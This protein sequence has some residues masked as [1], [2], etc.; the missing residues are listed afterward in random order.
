MLDCLSF[1]LCAIT[2]EQLLKCPSSGTEGLRVQVLEEDLKGIKIGQAEESQAQINGLVT[3]LEN[4]H[5]D[6]KEESRKFEILFA[7][8][9]CHLSEVTHGPSR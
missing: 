1:C 8:E 4:L 6:L 5:E 7:A 2:N 3:F 9:R